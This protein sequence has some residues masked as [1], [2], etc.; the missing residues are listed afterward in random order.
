MGKFKQILTDVAVTFVRTFQ[1]RRAEF[2][3]QPEL[4]NEILDRGAN[5]AKENARETLRKTYK[6]MGM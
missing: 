3:S 5:S 1:E 4:I 2:A 6:A